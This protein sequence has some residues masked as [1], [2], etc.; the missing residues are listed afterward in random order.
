MSNTKIVLNRQSD[1]I[2]DN[3]EITAPVGIVLADIAGAPEAIAAEE[4][5]RIA[6]DTELTENLV[7][8][9][10]ARI[11]AVS[12]EV[13]ARIAGDAAE[14]SLRIAGD[15]LLIDQVKTE[16]DNLRNLLNEYLHKLL[17]LQIFLTII[18]L[19]L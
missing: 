7:K 10:D 3:A 9:E 1:L 18:F 8:E 19:Y 11:A 2:L 4:L 15:E 6:G 5:L 14:T 16:K 12:T 13:S 17:N